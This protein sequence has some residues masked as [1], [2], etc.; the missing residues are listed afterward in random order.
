MTSVANCQPQQPSILRVSQGAL[1]LN[2]HNLGRGFHVSGRAHTLLPLP[3]GM[4]TTL[5]ST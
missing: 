4:I 1:L 5:N 2:L 3:R